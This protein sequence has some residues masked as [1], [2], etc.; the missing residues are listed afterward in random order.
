MVGALPEDSTEFEEL[1]GYLNAL[2]HPGR[3]E[4]LAQLRVPRTVR[5]MSLK[6]Y[7]RETEG[8]PDRLISRTALERH[9]QLLRA[10]GVVRSREAQ[11][12]GRA[13]EEY[14]VNQ[15]RLFQVVEALR[16]LSHLR[17]AANLD[18]EVT[19]TGEVAR[20]APTPEGPHVVCLTGPLEG[21]ARA[22]GGAGPW[23][24]GRSP[25]VA[26]PL[27]YDPYASSEHARI[28][29]GTSG[30]TVEDLPSSRNGTL[31]NWRPVPPGAPVPLKT[32]DVVSVGRSLLLFRA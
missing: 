8:N 23:V 12:D 13:V 20:S 24:L 18:V 30:F 27:D 5:E 17:P 7:R 25:T 9:L 21:H 31:L 14:V 26:I 11:R 1:A 2:S 29:R 3:L 15:Q 16:G 19:V 22:L 10:I 6:P 32:G 28:A 4:L